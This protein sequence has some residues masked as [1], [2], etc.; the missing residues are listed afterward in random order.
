[1]IPDTWGFDGSLEKPTFNPSVKITGKKRVIVNG[2]WTGEWVRDAA[3]S[4][5]D[6][7]CHYNLTAG[8]LHFHGDSTHGLKGTIVPLPDL[9]L[10]LR[11]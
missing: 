4:A 6:E 8:Q 7:C 3:G 9:P 10:H 5:V 1:M 2:Q 11:D